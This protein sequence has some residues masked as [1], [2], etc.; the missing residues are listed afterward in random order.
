MRRV[1]H[2]QVACG[3]IHT[4]PEPASGSSP[5]GSSLQAAKSNSSG[6]VAGLA[7]QNESAPEA[8]GEHAAAA[9]QNLRTALMSS[10]SRE[11]GSA[12]IT[13][14]S[15]PGRG[16][17][18]AQRPLPALNR[19][20]GAEQRL[21]GGAR[22]VLAGKIGRGQRIVVVVFLGH[23][24]PV[25][26]ASAMAMPRH[27]SS[28]GGLGR[29]A[30]RETS[31]RRASCVAPLPEISAA[32]SCSALRGSRFRRRGGRRTRCAQSCR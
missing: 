25:A 23:Q 18:L 13:T 3:T 14:V 15:G 11:N 32:A 1:A 19:V 22:A 16:G 28:S 27:Q 24:K 21:I 9:L 31:L 10:G 5:S 20:V 8:G 7:G 6:R 4:S 30:R 12:K 2:L 29:R 17:Q 26:T